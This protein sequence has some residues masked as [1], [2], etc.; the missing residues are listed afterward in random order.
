MAKI[1]RRKR[2]EDH[3]AHVYLTKEL[4]DIIVERAAAEFR[5]VNGQIQFYV[6]K[7]IEAENATP[8]GERAGSQDSGSA[9]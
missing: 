1:A 4:Y 5:S 6:A 7:G 2:G 9:T 8:V 3:Q